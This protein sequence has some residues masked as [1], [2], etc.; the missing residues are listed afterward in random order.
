M[1]NTSYFF[2]DS[3]TQSLICSNEDY[4][5]LTSYTILSKPTMW[6]QQLANHLNTKHINFAKGGNSPQGIIDDFIS[7]MNNFKKG[8]YVFI[9][10]SPMVRT[11]GYDD[12]HKK[13]QT[14]NLDTIRHKFPILEKTDD[15]NYGSPT[16]VQDKNELI[17]DYILT[18]LAPFEDEWCTYFEGKIKNFI[19]L[20]KKQDIHVYYWSYNLWNSFSSLTHETNSKLVNEHWGLEGMDQFVE[21]MKKRIDSKI[22]FTNE[23]LPPYKRRI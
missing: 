5:K 16:I 8:D 22:Y 18:Y 17:L 15:I 2:G 21:Y 9:S 6:S 13:I 20:F 7:N 23:P 19:E 11:I 1:Q 4:L 12:D 14:W 10:T 3:F